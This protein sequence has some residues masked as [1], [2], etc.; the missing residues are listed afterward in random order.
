[1][2][3]IVLGLAFHLPRL[4]HPLGAID[5]NA[6]KYFGPT[7]IAYEEIGFAELRGLP[8]WLQPTTRADRVWPY[9]THPPGLF[10]IMAALGTG[11]AAMRL[12][13]VIGAILAA[14]ALLLLLRPIIGLWPAF[15]AGACQLGVPAMTA[16][17]QTSYAPVVL[18]LGLWLLLSTTELRKATGAAACGW[19]AVQVATCIVGPWIDW[20]FALYCLGLAIVTMRWPLRAWISELVVPAVVTIVSVG[21][22]IAWRAC[23]ASAPFLRPTLPENDFVEMALVPFVKR[24]PLDEFLTAASR[25]LVDT[26]GLPVALLGTAGMVLLVARAPRLTMGLLV[27]AASHVLV[28]STHSLTHWGHYNYFAAPLAAGV[29]ALGVIRSGLL[30]PIAAVGLVAAVCAGWAAGIATVTRN[31]TDLYRDIGHTAVEA[32]L[33]PGEGPFYDQV[34][35]LHNFGGHLPYYAYSDWVIALPATDVLTLE[36]M[37]RSKLYEHGFRYLWFK[38]PQSMSKRVD[39]A[40]SAFLEPYP[41]QR[42]LD[43]ERKLHAAGRQFDG[44]YDGYE[45]YLVSVPF[46]RA[47]RR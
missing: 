23:I 5:Q 15:A 26:T 31:E 14:I 9:P 25:F 24:A 36:M 3:L 2:L 11:E 44:F 40:L 30:R 37:R 21:L 47:H 16:Y 20:P 10:W 35:V 1:M 41:R 39:P 32:T 38:P 22:F 8:T 42:L 29:G 33:Q 45:I 7:L 17:G 43:L 13:T 12:P 6:G 18:A 19:R 34:Y 27:A 28:F 46:A 4:H